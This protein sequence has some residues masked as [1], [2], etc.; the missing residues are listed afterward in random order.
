MNV[1]TTL[2]G[3]FLSFSLVSVSANT[4]PSLMSYQGRV[5][6]AAGALIGNANPVNR[7]VTFRF[8]TASTGG[9][10]IY[11]ET[12]TVTISVGEFSVL[13]GNG[14]GVSGSPGSS[15]P[16]STPYTSLGDIV[17]TSS[18]TSLYLGI[19]VDDGN[20]ATVDA[21]IA[22]RQQLVSGAY[23]LR[24]KV[25]ETVASGAVSSS[26]I[27]DGA[28]NTNQITANAITS[29]KISDSSIVAADIDDSAI[30]AAKIDTNSVGVWT[31]SG[32][33]VY[34]PNGSVGIGQANPVVPLTFSNT[35]GNKIALYGNGG[36]HYGL[37]IQG[38]LLQ[39]YT[40]GSA[41]DVAFGY[42]NSPAMTETMR[43]KGNGNVGI[44][45]TTPSAKLHVNG[46]NITIQNSGSHPA[47]Q[48]LGGA[49]AHSYLALA[50][51]AGAYSAWAA[52]NDTVLRSDK[53]LLL[54]SGSGNAALTVDTANRVGI[55][56]S[57]PSTPLD[58]NG[59][60]HAHDAAAD[61]SYHGIIRATRPTS[62]A[63]YINMVRS[64]NYVW[65]L[66]YTPN[67]ND[68]AIGHGKGND[69]QFAPSF[70]IQ[71]GTNKVGINTQNYGHGTLNVAGAITSIG[72]KGGNPTYAK[73]YHNGGGMRFEVY[74]SYWH[75]SSWAS[76]TYDGDNNIDF[77]SDARLKEN[78]ED[79]EPMLD[80][81]L[82]V[83]FRR[84]NWIDSDNA[85]KEFGVIAQELQP[86]FPDLIGQGEDGYYTVG[87]TSFATIACKAI[88]E[89][90]ERSDLESEAL[91]QEIESVEDRLQAQLMAKDDKIASLEAR[92]SALEYLLTAGK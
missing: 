58:V 59:V 16:A 53:K 49:S 15:S 21:E 30:T 81:L 51:S 43:I 79:A 38:N 2:L 36:N 32:S 18:T 75:P 6:D 62:A 20:G 82:Q 42:G 24:A 41:S 4:V 31:P 90:K 45:T 26:M 23:S 91:S 77:S 66:G 80:R 64:G 74:G 25:A 55:A 8:Y 29:A 14:T 63:Q 65:S 68:F 17:N 85:K 48:L 22:P 60:I 73:M 5:T 7:S 19:T 69:S 86:L 39:L 88:Q 33:N 54:Q 11:A 50:S 56:T 84:Y 89:L 71:A 61:N 27:A 47:L 35:L 67:T 34:R 83:D 52:A 10:A 87:Y 37:G 28:V 57:T 1:K 76:F 78:I 9:A 40:S 12:Q 72:S 92:L 13:I 3:L 44:G 70:S 46:G